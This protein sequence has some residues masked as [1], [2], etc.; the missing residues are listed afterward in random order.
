MTDIFISYNMFPGSF[1]RVL[2]KMRT[3]FSSFDENGYKIVVFYHM[4]LITFVALILRVHI[5]IL[6]VKGMTIILGYLFS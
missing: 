6:A 4:N 3:Q 1:S 2:M 5:D